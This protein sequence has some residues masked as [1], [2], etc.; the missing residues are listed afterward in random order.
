MFELEL[1][2]V[3]IMIIDAHDDVAF[4]FDF[5]YISTYV[6]MYIYYMYNIY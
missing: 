4:K 1:L 5:L 3:I 2:S 6:C